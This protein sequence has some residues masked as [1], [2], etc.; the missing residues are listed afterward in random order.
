MSTSLTEQSPAEILAEKRHKEILSSLNSINVSIL[1]FVLYYIQQN[2]YSLTG[3]L[4]LALG[5]F[6]CDKLFNSS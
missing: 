5:I 1:T 2:D 4:S 3:Y 6:V